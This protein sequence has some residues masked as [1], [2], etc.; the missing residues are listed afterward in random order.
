MLTCACGARF[1]VDNTLAGQDVLCPE[2][3]QPLKAPAQDRLP[4]V[5]SGWALASVVLALVGAFTI[6]G[7]VLAVLLGFYALRHISR[8]R[9]RVRGIGLA[10]FGIYLGTKFTA[11]TIL[12]LSNSDL[13][14]LENLMRE[15]F[16]AEQVDT[17]GPLE[18]VQGAK[19]FAITRPSEKWGQVA[20]NQSD[21]PAVSLLQRNRDLLLMQVA[22]YAFLD[23]R[24]LPPGNIRNLDQC[25]DDILTEFENRPR[26]ANP[27]AEDD[28]D[29]PAA[30]HARLLASRQ[31][32]TK[33]GVEGREMD[34]D[35]RSGGQPWRFTIRLYRRGNGRIYVVRAYTQKRRYNKNKSEL[36]MALDSFRILRR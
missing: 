32:E 8:N 24:T 20:G 13:F 29:F 2:C 30:I 6:V 33:D 28:D 5:T 16:T 26:Q 31:L 36:E 34:V 9:Q 15:K 23:V 1:E 17:S 4:Q 35:V 22:R 27:F 12:A 3:Q 11:L 18:V 25:Q 7:T 10:I 21:D 19:G 14:G